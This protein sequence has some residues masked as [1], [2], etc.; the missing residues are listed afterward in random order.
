MVK[1]LIFFAA[2]KDQKHYFQQLIEKVALPQVQLSM[3]AA[4]DVSYAIRAMFA[5]LLRS[6]S[7]SIESALDEQVAILLK[8][9]RA[10]RKGQS[11]PAWFWPLFLR[12]ETMRAKYLYW[13]YKLWLM[14]ENDIMVA[15][16]NG[17]KFRQAILV[18]AAKELGVPLMFFETGPLPGYSVVD[19]EGV[20]FFAAIPRIAAFYE[21]YICRL[22]E[23]GRLSLTKV[24]KSSDLPEDYIFVPF[25]VV[26]DSNIYLHSPWIKDMRHLYAQIERLAAQF[27]ARQFVIK[28]HPA[29]PEDYSDLISQ[30]NPQIHFVTDKPTTELVQHAQAVITVNST[31]GMEALLARKKVV[32]LGQAIYGFPGVSKPVEHYQALADA[33][34]TLDGW[35]LDKATLDGFLCYLQFDYAIPGDAM[36]NPGEEHW[37]GLQCKLNLFAQNRGYE[38]IGL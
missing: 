28:P 32:V 31:V 29:C 23:S 21:N 13:R 15:V 25:Q 16:W 38:A 20:D 14:H 36:R 34:E 11:R 12:A 27:P 9:K 35:V 8:R 22:P 5:S 6:L 30:H 18:V 37:S 4:S 17:K 19:P 26:E 2:S 7:P 24:E 33:I 3:Q 1:R 10:S